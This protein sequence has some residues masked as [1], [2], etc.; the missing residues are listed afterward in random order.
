LP[1]LRGR[2][3][4]PAETSHGGAAVAIITEPLAERLFGSIDVVGRQIE[5]PNATAGAVPLVF[6]IVGIAPGIQQAV[7][8]RG[9]SSHLYLSLGRRF[10]SNLF[11]HVRAAP[12]VDPASMLGRVRD[13]LRAID[14]NLPLLRLETLREHRDG[15]VF[16]WLIRAGGQVFALMGLL[17][18]G[19]AAVGIYGVRAFVTAGRTREIGL[20]MAL[21]ATSGSVVRQLLRESLKLTVLGLAL[22]LVLAV[23][24]ARL[25][26]GLLFEVSAF[27]PLV[28]AVA[29]AVLAAATLFATYLPARRASR[30]DPL[31]ALRHD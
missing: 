25:L 10:E 12:G 7:F 11:V 23:G 9:P 5:V 18:L 15:S 22:G 19:L 3:F 24:I 2:G 14:P 28:F 8:D 1:L 16:I 30:I 21:G 6:E 17:A 20:R 4:T 27:D 26:Q 29:T 31:A 13:E